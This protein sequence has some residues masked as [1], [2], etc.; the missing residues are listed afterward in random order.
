MILRLPDYPANRRIWP[1]AFDLQ[2]LI[3]VGHELTLELITRNTRDKPFTLSQAL[4]TYF[5]VGDIRQVRVAGLEQCRYLDKLAQGKVNQQLGT[6]A[7]T[8]EVDRI[9]EAE[10]NPLIIDDPV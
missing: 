5:K 10:K 6:L 9:Y 4:H 1:Y 2:L 7:V 8:Q 3:T